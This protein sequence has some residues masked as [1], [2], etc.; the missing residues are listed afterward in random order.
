[1]VRTGGDMAAAPSNAGP[2][3]D[4]NDRNHLN[5]RTGRNDGTARPRPGVRARRLLRPTLVG[6]SYVLLA[7]LLY[8]PVSP[9]SDRTII[10]CACNDPVQETWFLH[11][12]EWAVLHGHNPFFTYYLHAPHGANLALNTSFPLLGVLALPITVLGGPLVAYN[13]LL[14]L[15]LAASAAAMYGVLRRY[16]T[17]WP[18]AYAGGLLYGFSAYQL[19]HAHRH[20]FLT[21]VPLLPLFIPVVDDWLVNRRRGPVRSGLLV[22]LLTAGEFLISPEVALLAVGAAVVGLLTLAVRHRAQ[23]RERLRTLGL[24]VLA[25]AGVL[26]PVT[27]YP[28]YL[29]LAGH[30]RPTGPLHALRD[31]YQYHGDLVAPVVPTYGELFASSTAGSGIVGGRPV[32]NGFYLGAPL[33]VLLVVLVW[34]CR[35]TALVLVFTVLAL[36]AFLFSLGTEL[37]IDGHRVWTAMP[38][39]VLARLPVLQNIEPARLSLFVQLAAAVIVAIGLDRIRAAGWRRRPDR[40]PAAAGDAGAVERARVPRRRTVVVTAVAVVALLPLL[41]RLPLSTAAVRVPA[42]FTSGA[43]DAVPSGSLAM[44]F[45]YSKTPVDVPMLWQSASGMRFRIFGGMAFVP[46][47]GRASTWTP[48]PPAPPDISD[49]L[50]AGRQGHPRPVTQVPGLSGRV[51]TFL[52]RYRVDVVL[53]DPTWPRARQVTS[54]LSRALGRGPQ[55]IRDMDVWLGVPG[56]VARR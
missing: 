10:D 12:T 6:L 34:R 18:A 36:V 39:D 20:L 9:F 24:G 27:G 8:W 4:Q 3:T 30:E 56:L 40:G 2:S 38:F 1:M 53:V 37:T 45:P 43:V 49:L 52:R 15:A 17:W 11:W 55:R 33:L 14:R 5:D 26:V 23:V 25:G 35:R 54:V 16:T 50:L 31:L 29:L 13:V 46:G 7:C 32:E 41:P 48:L 47:A 28:V 44:T 22:G 42:F 51:V 19:G 21:F